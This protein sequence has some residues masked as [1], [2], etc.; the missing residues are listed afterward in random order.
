MTE[1]EFTCASFYSALHDKRLMG[2]RC[3]ECGDLYLPPRQIC[4]KCRSTDVEWVPMK[5]EGK[6]IT[7]TT[8]AVGTSSMVAA[9]YDRYRHY[10]CGIVELDEGPRVCAHILGVDAQ[11]PSS[12]EVGTPM[13]IEFPE[14]KGES[15]ILTFRV[16]QAC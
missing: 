11:N 1:A 2:T 5:G 16:R 10:C 15:S 12:I 3:K 6:L 13:T 9:G 8:I 4:L 14:A 7:F